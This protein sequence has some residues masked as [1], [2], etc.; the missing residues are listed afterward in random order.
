MS[1]PAEPTAPGL[2][3]DRIVAYFQQLRPQPGNYWVAFS[4]GVDSSV[5]LH[6]LASVR[7][8]L[9]GVLHAIHIDH[10]L[11]PA[12]ADWAAHCRACC[13]A[14]GVPIEI[15]AVD[16]GA[17]QGQS[18]EAAA[19]DARYAEIARA[20]APGDMLLTAHHQDDQAETVLLQLLR[21]A[22]VSGLSGMPLC[23][24]WRKGWLVR[25]L[26]ATPRASIVQWARDHAVAWIDDPSNALPD[27]D[28]NFLRHH[29]MPA[30]VQRW[31]TASRSIARSAQLCAGAAGVIT[32]QADADLLN[33]A[34]ANGERL[35]L[36]SLCRLNEV[37]KSNVLR[38]WLQQ[39]DTAPM[40]GARLRQA[41]DQLCSARSD[42]RVRIAWSN[43]VLRCFQG[44]LWL[45][46]ADEDDVPPQ[47][48]R[49]W[50]GDEID[51]GPGLGR[52]GSRLAAG[53]IDPRYWDDSV[54]EIAYR[55]PG[56]ACRPAGRHG[57]RG[58]K[59]LA[60]EL[61][62]PPWLRGRVPLVLIDGQTAAIAG[63]L[64]CEPFAARQGQGIWPVWDP[65]S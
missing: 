26:L 2:D 27:A 16:A 3:P 41:L 34:Q 11:Q 60:Q 56:M 46:A 54:V 43:H 35:Q 64:V 20:M 57:T 48:R 8:R 9:P 39:R 49:P 13:E 14:L 61:G 63:Y 19:R 45:L 65:P 52:L 17:R 42:A 4:G 31:P 44:Q 51:L 40:P 5:L 53:G 32:E 6:L 58:F 62:I 22:G 12:S 47:H 33:I 18:P 7:S 25:P 37:R 30:M 1:L 24:A 10:G 15:R 59:Q 21:G 23:R 55:T 29:V 50:A 28:R 38:R 36:E